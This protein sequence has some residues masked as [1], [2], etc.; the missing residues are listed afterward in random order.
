MSKPVILVSRDVNENRYITGETRRALAEFA[1]P[2]FA[3]DLSSEQLENPAGLFQDV[4][5]VLLQNGLDGALP[6]GCIRFLPKLE[7][8]VL[9]HSSFPGNGIWQDALK[10]GKACIEG[11]DAINRAVAEWTVGCAIW[12]RRRMVEAGESLKRN[13]VWQQ[14]VEKSSLLYGSTVGLIGLGQIGGMVCR[15][16]TALG[17]RIIAYDKYV[18]ETRAKEL[19]AALVSLPELL[20]TADVISLHAKV[21]EE[22]THMLKRH[23]FL[24]MR[25]GTLFLNS[26]R[27]ALYDETALINAV[28][29]GHISACIDVFDREP[30]AVDHIF[31]K[32]DNLYISSH[33]AGTNQP[34]YELA[35]R[36]AAATLKH[37][38]ATGEIRD[39]RNQF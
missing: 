22:T 3:D 6:N 39:S 8:V 7:L 18:P 2:I 32:L 34:M 26:A 31:H 10:A 21:T 4:R 5:A 33:I 27:S 38:F 36:Q 14:N 19:G 15:Y 11:S 28:K 23:E 37:Y 13:G 20:Q 1:S 25:P 35:G 12:G 17:C 16:L 24:L 9:I 29:S 30:L